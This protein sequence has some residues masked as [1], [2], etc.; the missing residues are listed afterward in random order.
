MHIIRAARQPDLDVVTSADEHLNLYLHLSGLESTQTKP[1]LVVLTGSNQ[2]QVDQEEQRT[3]A[4]ERQEV[5]QSV[6]KS[7]N[8]VEKSWFATALSEGRT[9]PSL[10]S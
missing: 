10:P 1:V 2:L 5:L 6:A 4:E 9:G 8:D 7:S 3:W